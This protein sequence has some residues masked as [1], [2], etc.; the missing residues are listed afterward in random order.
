MCEWLNV[1]D[2]L[3]AVRQAEENF[4]LRGLIEQWIIGPLF[5]DRL[6]EDLSTEQRSAPNLQGPGPTVDG[7][8]SS[9]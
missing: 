9:H 1:C 2:R 7:R 8:E 4:A 6:D 5:L 3:R